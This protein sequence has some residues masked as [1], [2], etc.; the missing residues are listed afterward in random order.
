MISHSTLNPFDHYMIYDRRILKLY[1]NQI[2]NKL[3]RAI[4]ATQEYIDKHTFFGPDTDAEWVGW[5]TK[6]NVDFWNSDTPFSHCKIHHV[7]TEPMAHLQAVKCSLG[8]SDL[9]CFIADQGMLLRWLE[10]FNF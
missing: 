3:T 9:M 8:F 7:V 6:E 5:S 10:I 4:Y 2:K 1:S